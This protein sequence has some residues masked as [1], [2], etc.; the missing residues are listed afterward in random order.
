MQQIKPDSPK[1]PR[2]VRANAVRR[3]FANID[4]A[5]LNGLIADGMLPAPIRPR[6]NLVLFDEADLLAAV[7]RMRTNAA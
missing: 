3:M 6:R 5:T 1:L 2:F 4:H 7:Q